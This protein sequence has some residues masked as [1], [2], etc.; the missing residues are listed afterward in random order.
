MHL[1]K[2]Y[3]SNIRVDLRKWHNGRF[4][5]PVLASQY[6]ALVSEIHSIELYMYNNEINIKFQFTCIMP[7]SFT[8]IIFAFN[9]SPKKTANKCLLQFSFALNC[10]QNYVYYGC[11]IIST[12]ICINIFRHCSMSGKIA[13]RHKP[14]TKI[15]F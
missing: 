2:F 5:A 4:W 14:Q 11:F 8:A 9:K 3:T 1:F 15:L 10:L 7:I 12:C 6:Q 13:S